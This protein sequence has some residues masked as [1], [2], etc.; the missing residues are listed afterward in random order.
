MTTHDEMKIEQQNIELIIQEKLREVFK[1]N[2]LYFDR[3]IFAGGLTNYNYI[4][5]I[6][7]EDYVIREPGKLTKQMID[8]EIEQMNNGIASEFGVNSECIYFD[9]ET[10]IKI[11]RFIPNSKNLAQSDPFS[12]ES[13]IAVAHLMKKIHTS[14]VH[15]TNTFEWLEE[16]E[17][18][19][20][21]I[22]QLKG[23][24]F[25]D[26]YALKEKLLTFFADHLTEAVLVPCH[27]DTV[28]E[29]FLAADDGRY[30][31][32]DWEY[33]GLNDANWDLAAYI[34]ETRLPS[35][36][37]DTLLNMYYPEGHSEQDILKIKGY[38]MA[39]DLLWT[40]WALIRHYCG[41]NFLDYCD[42]RY[43]RFRK[44]ILEL[45]DTTEYPLYKMVHVE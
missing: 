2:T 13:L 44:N 41:D 22:E 5:T 21:I 27:N 11:S 19:E 39:Q 45:S 10:G 33:S 40:V 35:A 30:Y 43:E 16:L 20:E 3:S 29:N 6:A 9:A 15:F 38:I 8:R 14:P 36:S 4:M 31:L 28:P 26:Y 32:I 18:Y 17:K 24:L 42:M 37:I 25:F 12:Q 23:N 7:G 1:D 34:I